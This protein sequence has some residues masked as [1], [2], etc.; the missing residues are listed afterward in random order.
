MAA[1][2]AISANLSD[3]SSSELF[4]RLKSGLKKVDIDGE[5]FYRVEGD[6]LLDEDQ[7]QVYAVDKRRSGSTNLSS[8][9]DGL[10][11]NM[12]DGKIA[13]WKLGTVLSYCVIRS[14]FNGDAQYNE[15]CEAMR[16]A[17]SDWEITCGVRFQYRN[18]LDGSNPTPAPAGAVFT[19]R[20]FDANGQFI[21][22]AFF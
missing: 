5:T 1:K 21:A 7:L 9:P 14:T 2:P 19:V 16:Q 13:R 6:M 17:T 4:D 8:R 12:V 3:L 20:E 15:V 22:A 10:L 18:D 11:A